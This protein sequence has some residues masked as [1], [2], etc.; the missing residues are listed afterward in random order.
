[1]PD[2]LQKGKELDYYFILVQGFMFIPCLIW[3]PKLFIAY[4]LFFILTW[5]AISFSKKIYKDSIATLIILLGIYVTYFFRPFVLYENPDLVMFHDVE[6]NNDIILGILLG[7]VLKSFVIMCGVVITDMLF[8]KRRYFKTVELP[9]FILRTLPFLL[10]ISTFLILLKLFLF[11]AYGI[12]MKSVEITHPLAFLLRF[13]PQDLFYAVAILFFFTSYKKVNFIYKGGMITITILFSL[14]VLLTGSK[15]FLL[16]MGFGYF[17]FFLFKKQKMTFKL[18]SVLMFASVV[19]VSLSFIFAHAIKVASYLGISPDIATV[20]SLAYTYSSEM[21]V[22]SL[23]DIVTGR[24]IGL[25]GELVLNTINQY[26]EKYNVKELREIFS[27]KETAL[28]VVNGCIPTAKVTNSP[29]MGVGVSWYVHGFSRD[30]I[31]AGAI[32][33]FSSLKLTF[34]KFLYLGLFSYG[35]LLGSIYKIIGM[36]RGETLKYILLFIFSLFIVIVSI[37]G[38]FDIQIITLVMKLAFLVFYGFLLLVQRLI[39]KPKW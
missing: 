21:D 31:F 15:S 32:G 38:N 22:I 5:S 11:F 18:F 19:G 26:P 33:I 7:V 9:N 23:I 1:M 12:G 39:V 17:V 27:M 20:F 3:I 34:G 24:L 35:F 4:V 36:I 10:I 28:R 30:F 29:S 25:D 37:S 6:V 2:N 16:A 8:I 14:S 13:I